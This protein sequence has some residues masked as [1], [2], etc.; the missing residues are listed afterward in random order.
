[1][2]VVGQPFCFEFIL[3]DI[4]LHFKTYWSVLLFHSTYSFIWWNEICS[5][6]IGPI[7]ISQ[8]LFAVEPGPPGVLQR[9]SQ[10]FDFQ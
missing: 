4:C 10:D 5:S 9:I 8:I 1:M 6:K 2:S 7:N 3:V